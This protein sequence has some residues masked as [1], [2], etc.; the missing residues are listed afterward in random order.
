MPADAPAPSSPS[1]PSSGL[2]AVLQLHNESNLSQHDACRC[3]GTFV[4]RSHSGRLYNTY[5]AW[6]VETW[7]NGFIPYLSVYH[8]VFYVIHYYVIKLGGSLNRS[9]VS[10]NRSYTWRHILVHHLV[11]HYH[12]VTMTYCLLTLLDDITFHWWRH[13]GISP[14]ITSL[15]T[16]NCEL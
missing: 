11:G 10:L 8:L 4:A 6:V 3:P 16:E 2:Y 13:N 5:T 1:Q 12:D 15:R 9:S 7:L 14:K